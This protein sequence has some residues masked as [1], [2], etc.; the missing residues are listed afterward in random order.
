MPRP[1]VINKKIYNL[2]LRPSDMVDESREQINKL[3]EDEI[4]LL[5]QRD[6]V[7]FPFKSAQIPKTRPNLL[8]F[9]K[10]ELDFASSLIE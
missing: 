2:K 1:K 10:N 6:A 4:I 9:T 7:D 8:D 5:L 3:L